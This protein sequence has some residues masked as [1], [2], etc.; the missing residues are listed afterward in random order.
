MVQNTVYIYISNVFVSVQKYKSLS[1]GIGQIPNLQARIW[2]V[3][4]GWDSGGKN[5]SYDS[6]DLLNNNNIIK[7]QWRGTFWSL[8][9][10]HLSFSAPITCQE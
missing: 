2:H 4:H 7:R 6:I 5:S 9:N 3:N 1:G 10:D 8:M